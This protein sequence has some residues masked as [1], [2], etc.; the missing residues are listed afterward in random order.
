[1]TPSRHA[2]AE[3][4][5][6]GS[7]ATFATSGYALDNVETRFLNHPATFDIPDRRERTSLALSSVVKLIFLFPHD[8]I[9][10]KIAEHGDW[11]HAERMWVH[12]HGR[13][14]MDNGAIVYEGSLCNDPAF[15]D[16]QV[17]SYGDTVFFGPEHIADIR[18]D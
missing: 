8:V 4:G 12:V 16:A 15:F 3:R 6:F 17:L 1:M 2:S 10:A 9:E 7:F 5:V 14:T 11:P 18:L 13:L